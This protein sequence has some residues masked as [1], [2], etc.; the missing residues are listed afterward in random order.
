MSDEVDE[1][2]AEEVSED[3]ETT[4]LNVA[5][6][7]LPEDWES[8]GEF[9]D[10][11]ISEVDKI[12]TMPVDEWIQTV[13]IETTADVPIPEKLVDR[14]IG[15]ESANI[16]IKKAAEQRRHMMMI[17]DPGTGKSMLARAMTELMPDDT[18]ED[19]LCYPN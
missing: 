4:T 1:I 5:D 15:Q 8:E 6:A 9:G 19:T 7:P 17:G 13:D 11:E 3:T 18:L 14:V 10:I 2:V 16:V 12:E